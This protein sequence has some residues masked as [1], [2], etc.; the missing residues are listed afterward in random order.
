MGPLISRMPPR[1]KT[2]SDLCRGV[3]FFA[4][5]LTILLTGMAVAQDVHITPRI[6]SKPAASPDV[7]IDPSLKTHTKPLRSDVDL[8]LVPVTVTD[9]MDRLVTGLEKNN[10]EVF[11]GKQKQQIHNLSSEDAPVT[12]GVILDMSGSM[13]NKF[14]KAK[15]A[16]VQFM[17]TANPED[18]FFIIG[19]SD[20]PLLLSDFTGSVG[21]IQSR[22][23]MAQPKGMTALLDAIYMGMNKMKQAK[24]ERK[25]LLIISDGGDNHSRYSESEIK[26]AVKEA[27]VQIFAIGLFDQ[28]PRTQEERFGPALLSEMTEVTG[29]RAFTLNDPNELPDVATKIGTELRNQYVIAYKPVAKPKDGKWHKIKVKLL[30]PRGL[31]MLNLHAKQGYYA[32]QE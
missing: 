13:N 16:V 5:L 31:P 22:L 26:S 30:P 14:D 27:D 15:E 19:F 6:A 21:E 18:E 9:P 25:A 17:Q 29:G 10:F 28:A 11:E 8:I 4:V 32:S 3:V 23:V 20:R 1:R 24:R 12:V 2:T 7:S